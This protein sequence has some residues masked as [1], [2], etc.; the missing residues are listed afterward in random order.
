MPRKLFLAIPIL[1]A[2]TSAASIP[3]QRSNCTDNT[4]AMR[5]AS[6]VVEGD[7]V[8]V[9]VKASFDLLNTEEPDIMFDDSGIPLGRVFGGEII[10]ASFTTDQCTQQ[11]DGTV[12]CL[13]QSS[14]PFDVS[15]NVFVART[16]IDLGKDINTITEKT[17]KAVKVEFTPTYLKLEVEDN[18][19]GAMI[20]IDSVKCDED[21]GAGTGWP[22][23]NAYF[24][25]RLRDYLQR[26]N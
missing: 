12:V 20:K 18:Y 10:F 13:W 16:V 6:F 24:P 2:V 3:E 21:G 25:V 5:V 8:E 4:F 22:F 1:F 15:D 14:G 17:V 11:T 26:G 9:G 23:G 7:R 19:T